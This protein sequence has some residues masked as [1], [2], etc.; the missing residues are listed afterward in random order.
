MHEARPRVGAGSFVQ[1]DG[2]ERYS[3]MIASV[4]Q[5]ST[6]VPHSVQMS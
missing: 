2:V 3:S 1:Q 4:G 5:T 6:Q